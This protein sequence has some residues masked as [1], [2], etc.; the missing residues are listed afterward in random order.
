MLPVDPWSKAAECD[1]A[2]AVIAD[3]ERRLVLDSLRNLWLAL[4]NEQS[5]FDR[6]DRA[7]QLSTIAQIHAELI[8]ECR[9]AMH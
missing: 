1:R 7:H 8:A 5:F 9:S 6:P 4:C 3:P 2:L